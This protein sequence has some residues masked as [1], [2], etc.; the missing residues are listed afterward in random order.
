VSTNRRRPFPQRAIDPRRCNIACDAN[1]L[2][3]G[4]TSKDRF[5]DRFIELVES[6][7]INVVV[8]GGVLD[9]VQHPRTPHDV[10]SVVLPRIFN[11]RPG[12]NSLQQAERAR[13]RTILQGNA[14]SDTHASDASHLSEAAETGCCYFITNDKRILKK[15]E[16]LR[17]ALPPT[18]IGGFDGRE[19]LAHFSGEIS[20]TRAGTLASFG[21]ST[22]LFTAVR[23]LDLNR[24]T[25]EWKRRVSS[26]AVF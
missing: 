16:E 6:R 19:T 8:A 11:L 21:C 26:S 22:R 1:A 7:V 25:S 3:R 20:I 2:D 15:R 23:G 24:V 14:K 12:L 4:G 18:L 5:V 9:E 17:S 13:V 10:K